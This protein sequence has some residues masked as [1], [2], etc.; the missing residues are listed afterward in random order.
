MPIKARVI[1]TAVL[2]SGLISFGVLAGPTPKAKPVD[3]ITKAVEVPCVLGKE[4]PW[5]GK[6]T[7][8]SPGYCSLEGEGTIDFQLGVD[9]NKNH[10]YRFQILLKKFQKDLGNYSIHAMKE[11]HI[12]GLGGKYSATSYT[13]NY[14]LY[15]PGWTDMFEGVGYYPLKDGSCNVGDKLIFLIS[16][17]K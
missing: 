1:A 11:E 4:A 10:V 13:T 5:K 6:G 17:G 12:G 8:C 2:I 15:A 7:F 14:D 3:V 16:Y 9:L